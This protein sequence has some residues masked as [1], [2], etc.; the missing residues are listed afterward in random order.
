[1]Y[2]FK[3]HVMCHQQLHLSAN[4]ITAS[5]ACSVSVPDSQAAT[6]MTSNKKTIKK[7][8]FL[9]SLLFRQ[10]PCRDCV[11]CLLTKISGL[12]LSYCAH[13]QVDCCDNWLQF[14]F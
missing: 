12:A 4:Q 13:R 10:D 9:V 2:C 11:G 8:I 6:I 7:Y 14:I 5:K 3:Q 1:M